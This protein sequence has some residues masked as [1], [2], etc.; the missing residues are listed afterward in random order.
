MTTRLR[1]PGE[2]CWFN[3][4]SPQ[5]AAGRGFFGELFGWTYSDIPNLGHTI[6]LGPHKIG[7]FF[8]VVLP[9][10]PATPPMIGILIKVADA[11]ATAKKVAALGGTV[12]RPPFDIFGNLRMAVLTDPLGTS[13]DVW[14]SKRE[15]GT[16]VDP[17]LHGAPIWIENVTT[18]VPRARRFYQELFGW[19]IEVMHPPGME[20]TVVK[21]GNEGVGG[22]MERRPDMGDV[23][24]FWTLYFNS[25]N[26]DETVRKAERM[27]GKICMPVTAVPNVGKIAAITSPQGVNFCIIQPNPHQ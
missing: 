20:Y 14:E 15:Q 22:I 18:D 16:D 10:A 26:A 13:F 27:G 11:D 9:G 25:R 3:L 12:V 1:N 24:P 7:A 21:A 4:M 19:A 6:H 8:D 5:P 17:S 2:L 23:L